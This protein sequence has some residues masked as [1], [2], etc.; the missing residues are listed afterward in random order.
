M[1]EIAMNDLQ[2]K[3]DISYHCNFNHSRIDMN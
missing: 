1:I 2:K 3:N